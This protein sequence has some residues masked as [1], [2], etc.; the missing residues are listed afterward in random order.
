MTRVLLVANTD[1]YL[2]NYRLSLA[3]TL[4]DRGFEVGLVSPPGQY[5]TQFKANGFPWFPWHLG[6]RT[7]APWNEI[8]AMRKLARIYRQE[9]PDLVHHHTIKPVI[10]GSF[11]SH[12]L[13]VKSVVNS[14][15]GRGYI[16]SS[17]DPK[18]ALLRPAARYLYRLA[19]RHPNL[20]AIFENEPDRQYFI[21]QK[22]LPAERAWV[23]GGVGV[24]TELFTPSPEPS[25]Q[26]VVLL[27][28]RMLWDKGIDLLVEAVRILRQATPVRVV[29]VGEPDPGNPASI[30]QEQLKNWS[31]EGLV[32]WWGWQVDMNQVYRQCHIVVLPTRYGEGVPTVLLEAA[33]CGRPIIATDVP[34]CKDITIDGYNGLLVPPGDPKALANAINKL[35]CDAD[36]R[37]R[38]GRAG[39]QLV[40]Q[41]FTVSLV[42]TDT[43]AVYQA[44]LNHERSSKT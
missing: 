22:L 23:I 8:P 41:M 13:G 14:I 15:T 38:M 20:A 42:N 43:F 4:R 5:T 37:G 40:L 9:K 24:D 35:I 2:Y 16:F 6:R 19:F 17:Q 30:D 33:A 34:G 18:A 12:A 3:K 11:V 21:Q 31:S 36:L 7:L 1:W 28:S 32:E 26:P 44:V 25:G 10:Y 27:A 29:L 39:R